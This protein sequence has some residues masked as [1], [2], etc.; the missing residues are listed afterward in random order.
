DEPFGDLGYQWH[1]VGD[2]PSN[3]STI[4]L[5]SKP[6]RSLT[7]RVTNAI[8]ALL[9]RA[10]YAH[11]DAQAPESPMAAAQAWFGRPPTTVNTGLYQLDEHKRGIMADLIQVVLAAGDESGK[12][13]ID[14][15]DRGIGIAPDEFDQ[16]IL[17]FHQGN[18]I[19]KAY[20]AG[21]FGQGGS[22]TI[23]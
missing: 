2:N 5:A 9:E 7:E 3:M 8:D 10:R 21:A 22:S 4:N 11:K 12:P 15:L 19:N 13:T 18:K 1:F 14:V 23:A 17:S 16:T 20:L 6:G